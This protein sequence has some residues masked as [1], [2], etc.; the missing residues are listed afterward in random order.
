MTLSKTWLKNNKHKLEYVQIE[1]Y[2]NEVIRRECR[3][4]GGVGV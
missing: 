1:V 3:N 2:N 4:G